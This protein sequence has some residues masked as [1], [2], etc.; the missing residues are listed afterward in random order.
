MI[1]ASICVIFGNKYFFIVHRRYVY[2]DVHV[3]LYL[4]IKQAQY[5]LSLTS[6]QRHHMV[7]WAMYGVDEYSKEYVFTYQT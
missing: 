3:P 2:P 6:R 1:D 4:C 7:S 5:P